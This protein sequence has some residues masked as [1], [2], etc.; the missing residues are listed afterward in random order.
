MFIIYIVM[1]IMVYFKMVS[2]AMFCHISKH[3]GNR[4]KTGQ[5]GHMY[6]LRKIKWIL[7]LKKK[8]LWPQRHKLQIVV[9][10]SEKNFQITYS[11]LLYVHI[12]KL[13]SM[14]STS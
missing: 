10:M 8:V 4:L 1:A 5:Y 9:A 2:A 3:A 6:D 11:L 7:C 12:T 13:V 14:T